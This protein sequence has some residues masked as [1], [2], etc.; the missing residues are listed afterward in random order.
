MAAE[1]V[2]EVVGGVEVMARE[3]VAQRDRAERAEA[4]VAR[5]R[6]NAERYEWLKEVSPIGWRVWVDDLPCWKHD[7]DAAIDAA[8]GVKS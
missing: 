2:V 4:E 7:L 8:R 5:L 1:T 3:L 6:V